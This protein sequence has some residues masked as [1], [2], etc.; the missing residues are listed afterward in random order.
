MILLGCLAANIYGAAV[1]ASS[2]S[3]AYKNFHLICYLASLAISLPAFVL[4]VC[5][6]LA[7]WW[8]VAFFG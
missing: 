1:S 3:S 2:A 6:P 5:G 8:L 7:I 4:W